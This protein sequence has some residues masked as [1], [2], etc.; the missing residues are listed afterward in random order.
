MLC[1]L[2]FHNVSLSGLD[3][4]TVSYF[5]KQIKLLKEYFKIV[6][7]DT[8][9]ERILTKSMPKKPE[10][11][12]T[13]DDGF[14]SNY[15]FVEPILRR[16]KIK[17]T[18]FVATS[19]IYQKNIKRFSLYDYWEGRCNLSDLDQAYPNTMGN[20][21][22]TS[23]YRDHFM[24]RE[25]LIEV[26]KGNL[27][28]E[29]H[30]HEHIKV[31]E[32]PLDLID[33]WDI[34]KTATQKYGRFIWLKKIYG[35]KIIGRYTLI[36]IFKFKSFHKIPSTK[37]YIH[38]IESILS[39]FN[40]GLSINDIKRAIKITGYSESIEEA[41]NRIYMD[42]KRAKDTLEDILGKRIIHLAWPF[43]EY[44]DISIEMAKKA[45]YTALY[46]TKK[47]PITENTSIY[48]IERINTPRKD[49]ELLKKI[50]TRIILR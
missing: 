7:I 21:V 25:E 33:I 15:A 27:K 32:Y 46:T 29:S 50:I 37:P 12:I 48:E 41:K 19:H 44:S 23:G 3:G 43:G 10:V 13:F 26:D 39:L 1:V 17:A 22:S 2:Y 18:V 28:V 40:K 36:P 34:N 5:E 6:D 11:A 42:L 20:K 45:G 35:E 49:L 24:T 38:E 9:A 8:V 14:Y 4:P 47:R 30:G 31:F 16:E